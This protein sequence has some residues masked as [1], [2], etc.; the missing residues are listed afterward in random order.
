MIVFQ[1]LLDGVRGIH[2]E[3]GKAITKCSTM[4]KDLALKAKA[5]EHLKEI[6]RRE[7]ATEGLS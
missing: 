6:I 4:P 7:F 1:N 2:H 3:S 5:R